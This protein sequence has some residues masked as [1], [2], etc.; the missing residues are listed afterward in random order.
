VT[1]ERRIVEA[2]EHGF[3]RRPVLLCGSRAVGEEAPGSDFDVLVV[4]PAPR[5][6][7]ALR[8]LRAIASGLT[9]ELG[10]P[11]TLNPLPQ[12]RLRDRENLFVWKLQREAKVLSA[13]EDFSLVPP[14]RAPLTPTA[15]FSY[16]LTA[17]FYLLEHLEPGS[18]AQRSLGRALERGT[19]KAL[20]HVAQM[21][22]MREGRYESRLADALLAL[23]ADDLAEAAG[24]GATAE[25]W[26]RARDLVL[27]E[28]GEPGELRGA[29][30]T[31]ARYAAL[32][33]LRGRSRVRA[34]LSRR[35]IDQRLGSAT[36]ALLSAVDRTGCVDD[37][38]V[39]AIRATLPP[40]LRRQA[41]TGWESLRDLL[42][43]EWPDAH[44][45]SAL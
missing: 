40:P 3:G 26:L 45:L 43:R 4:L 5:I 7:L 12:R 33:A 28:L 44:P 22:L 34:A 17:S 15:A 11:V 10:A 8:R 31:N 27:A 16:L 38:T 20:L 36:V 6:P 39:A 14:V 23:G 29:V 18:L 24:L 2:T 9:A 30:R 21:R 37:A 1:P 19:T 41:G 25:A 13:P 42:L 35:R 32:A